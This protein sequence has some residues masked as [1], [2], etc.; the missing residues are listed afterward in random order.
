MRALESYLNSVWYG[1]TGGAWLRPLGALYA[2]AM[3][4]RSAAYRRG[5]RDVYRAPCPVIVVGNY[6]AGGA[7]KTPLVIALSQRLRSL[8]CRPGIIS[9]GYGGTVTS[10]QAFL[11][12][13]ASDAS[14]VGDEPLLM[15]R[16]TQAPVAVC[17]DRRKAVECVTAQGANVI[18]ADDGLQHLALARDANIVV[19]DG[20]RGLGN[21]RCLPAG[22]LRGR[23]IDAPDAD[24]K[25]INGGPV[26]DAPQMKLIATHARQLDSKQCIP[27]SGWVG[28]PVHAVA[29]IGNPSRFFDTLR[30]AGIDVI[31]HPYADHA[32]LT[33]ADVSFDD[34]LPVLMTEKDAVRFSEA[35]HKRC[36]DVPADV[37]FNAAASAALVEL[38]A[39]WGSE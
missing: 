6:T 37:E 26:S 19:I 15:A 20:E 38:C 12:D 3:S 29:G 31:E 24:L 32:R 33:R 7:G 35:P 21:E 27:L 4:L 39:Q 18:V 16:R 11:V 36:F 23:V 22:P 5:W 30:G 1:D 14:V 28:S 13:P 10:D 34:D 25:M 17:P 2:S 9:R 8:G